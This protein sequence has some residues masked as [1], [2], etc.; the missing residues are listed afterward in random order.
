[1]LGCFINEVILKSQLVP[2][3][4][5]KMLL[6]RLQ[7]DIYEAIAHK[8][9]PFESVLAQIEHHAPIDLMASLT[10]TNSTQGLA[11]IPNWELVAMQTRTQQ[12]DDISAERYNPDTPLEFYVEMSQP[13]RVMVNYGI[14]RFTPETIDRLLA[15]YRSILTKLTTAPA[16]TVAHLL[17][18]AQTR[19]C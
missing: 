18:E 7:V 10:V 14:D 1:M 2:D 11:A 5:G 15:N 6:N 9:V 3:L 19:F 12:W 8:D 13:M 17:D 4:T 16:A